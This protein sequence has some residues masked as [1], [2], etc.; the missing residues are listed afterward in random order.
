MA[1]SVQSW[2]RDAMG[3]L[4]WLLRY[5]GAWEF[6]VLDRPAC[7]L[8]YV[9]REVVVVV[10]AVQE[11]K[12]TRSVRKEIVDLH[13]EM[14]L[15]LNY[16]AINYT[17]LLPCVP[18]APSLFLWVA[19]FCFASGVK[20]RR[21]IYVCHLAQLQVSIGGHLILTLNHP[22]FFSCG[23]DYVDPSLYLWDAS[24]RTTVLQRTWFLKS[25]TLLKH[26]PWSVNFSRY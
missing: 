22:A 8:K 16:S 2:R 13:G 14:V 11:L 4:I 24:R 1:C 17:G 25:N 7:S 20:W 10:C 6:K 12:E 18:G 21:R 23:M 3:Q 19:L 15:L 9:L 5:K 26:R